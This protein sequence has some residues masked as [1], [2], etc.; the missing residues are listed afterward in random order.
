MGV[1]KLTAGDGYLYATTD[2]PDHASP[3]PP[4][5]RRSNVLYP[6]SVV[7]APEDLTAA[8]RRLASFLRP[9]ASGD[10]MNV[11]EPEISADSARQLIAS[12]LHLARVFSTMAQRDES[13]QPLAEFFDSRAEILAALQ[14]QVRYLVDVAH[15]EPN[16]RRFW[17]QGEMTSAVA[18]M[19]NRGTPLTLQPMQMLQLAD[20]THQVTHNLG[21]SLRRELTRP[22]SNLR[23][24][25]PALEDAPFQIGRRSALLATLTDLL[26]SPAPTTPM[27]AYSVPLQRA[28]LRQ[29]LDL[30]PTAS[31]PPAPFPAASTPGV[32]HYSR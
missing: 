22:G 27:A 10:S 29:T 7:A 8:Q 18:R 21:R 2:S 19:Q 23:D 20:A 4:E 31:R 1:H 14:P 26:H 15:S 25:R 11:G 12:Q 32:N 28:A 13:T 17:Q 6:V 9:L 5:L 30:S 16:R 24:A 3:R